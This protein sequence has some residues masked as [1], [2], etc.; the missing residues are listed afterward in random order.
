MSQTCACT[1]EQF[2][3]KC[4]MPYPTNKT[5]FRFYITLSVFFTGQKVNIQQCQIYVTIRQIKKNLAARYTAEY[6]KRLSDLL[7][8]YEDYNFQ[9]K[10]CRTN[11]TETKCIFLQ[12]IK[13]TEI[14]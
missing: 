1:S 9:I 3:G 2:S 11:W 8:K 14:L 4:R 7:A 13:E 5:W 12:Q 10:S 6:D